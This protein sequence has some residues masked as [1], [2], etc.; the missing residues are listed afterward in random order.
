[1]RALVTGG[2]GF[3]GSHLVDVLLARGDEVTILD[4]LSTGSVANLAHALNLGATLVQGSVTDPAA[5]LHALRPVPAV[6]FHLA[7]QIDVRR[8]LRDPG[9]DATI[10]LLGTIALLEG[11]RA[12]GAPRIV[13]ASTGGAI[14]G[15]AET[16]PTPETAPERPLSPYAASKL[17]AE[18]YCELYGR[19]H[20]LG[21][22]VLRL[23]NVYG[24]RQDARGEGG[25]IARFTSGAPAT[26][27]G[28]GRQTRDFVYAPDVAEAFTAAGDLAGDGLCNV[29]TGTETTILELAAVLGLAPA[30]APARPGEVRRSCLDPTRAAALL[31]WRARTPL[32]DGLTSTVAATRRASSA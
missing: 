32:A 11:M 17:A 22:F 2:A 6:V 8:A 24:P 31:R 7:A 19:T 4:D 3:I 21:V 10:N 27:F 9:A 29:A 28:D 16:I 1:V 14:Y 15:D 20:G 18:R 23:A 5:V 12:A 30:F 13:L 25:V 26:V